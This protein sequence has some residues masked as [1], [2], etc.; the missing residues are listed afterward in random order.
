LS[1]PD[2]KNFLKL[3]IDEEGRLMIFPIGIRRVPR[4][5]RASDQ[6]SGSIFVPDDPKATSPEL[7]DGPIV[8][9]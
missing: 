8:V 1:I 9:P 3:K 2:W 4:K 5:W 6:T 7:I